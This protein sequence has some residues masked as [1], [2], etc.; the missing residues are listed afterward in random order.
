MSVSFTVF[1]LT[2]SAFDVALFLNGRSPLQ[3]A[4]GSSK[5]TWESGMADQAAFIWDDFHFLL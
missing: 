2:L 5:E 3:E 4:V 1:H